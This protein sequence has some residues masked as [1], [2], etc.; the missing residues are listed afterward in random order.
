[1]GVPVGD[2]PEPVV[3][4]AN[5]VFSVAE[6]LV[7]S[8]AGVLLLG[9]AVI[10]LATVAYHLVI[11]IGGGSL[12]AIQTALDGLLLMFILLEL[13]A[14]VRAT[15]I[16]REL[17]AEPFLLVGIIA[18]IKEIVVVTLETKS[19]SGFND[20]V[21]RAA[22]IEIG[23]LAGVILLLAVSILLVRRKEREPEE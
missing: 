23:V 9:G 22:M 15:L 20:E 7:Y 21:F 6:S 2:Q 14:G 13:L 5:R 18:S 3:R 16:Q 1:M 19:T 12:P 11:D 8:G 17:V 10:A 4:P